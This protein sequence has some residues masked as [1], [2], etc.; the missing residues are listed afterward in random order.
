M[1]SAHVR[2][3]APTNRVMTTT[4]RRRRNAQSGSV[5]SRGTGS[6][7][8]ARTKARSSVTGFICGSGSRPAAPVIAGPGRVSA[9]DVRGVYRARFRAGVHVVAGNGVGHGPVE[10]QRACGWRPDEVVEV[11]LGADHLVQQAADE[12]L[13]HARRHRGHEPDPLAGE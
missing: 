6:T 10:R 5:W 9:R 1:R 4:T 12:G 2:M 13:G 3:T 7:S 8:V 11:V